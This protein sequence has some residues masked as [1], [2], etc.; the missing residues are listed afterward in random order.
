MRL[1]PGDVIGGKYRVLRLI[2]DGGMGAVY[3][4]HHQMLG[5]NVA[6]KFLHPELAKRP[7][8]SSRFLQEARV[9]ARIQSPHVTRVTDVD[10]TPS[11][12]PFI[13]M[14]LL[15]G[16]SLQSLLDRRSKLPRDQAIDFALQILAGLEAAH[17]LGVVHR[18]LKPDNVFIT[19]STGG[20]VVKLLDF[21][22]AKLYDTSEYKKGLTRPGAIMGTP[23]YMAPEQLYSADKVDHR[24][25]LYSLGVLLYEMLAGERPAYGDDAATIVGKVAQGKVRRLSE[26]DKS[27]S[28]ALAELVHRAMAPEKDAR[29]A[30]AA[31]MRLALA[32]LAGELSQAGRLAAT[33]P[34]SAVASSPPP[35]PKQTKTEELPPLVVKETPRKSA[36]PKTLPPEED[37]TQPAEEGAPKGSTQEASKELIAEIS[38]QTAQRHAV[39]EPRTAQGPVPVAAQHAHMH[40]PPPQMHA[41]PPGAFGPPQPRKR[42]GGVGALVALL[43]GLLLTGGVIF[44]VVALRDKKED[45]APINPLGDPTPTTTIAPQGETPAPQP[46]PFANPAPSPTPT[47]QKPTGGGPIVTPKKDAGAA[48]QDGGQATPFPTFPLPSGLPPL[49]S[50]LPPIPTTI[51][52]F[53]WNPPPPPP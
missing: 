38:R 1:E 34:P 41:P 42:S 49:P 29:F 22:I 25:D 23:E 13:V 8:L 20:P 30:S 43:L 53:P 5:T 3:E 12:V 4:A 35:A 18:D 40:G 46:P 37:D 31:E 50:G 9:S 36:V 52:Q 28:G 21:G 10:Q 11:G 6:L 44:L 39:Q 15:S 32:N 47:P 17:A 14:E 48:A 7:G 19:P 2:G 45:P 27:L 26:H 24:A 16:E 51:P 33:P